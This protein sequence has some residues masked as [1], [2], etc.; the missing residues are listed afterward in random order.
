MQAAV[1]PPPPPPATPA[2][3][4]TTTTAR[5][6]AAAVARAVAAGGLRGRWATGRTCSGPSPAKS[7]CKYVALRPPP[8]PCMLYPLV[9]LPHLSLSLPNAVLAAVVAV[10]VGGGSGHGPHRRHPTRHCPAGTGHRSR[11]TRRGRRSGGDGNSGGRRR[12]RRDGGKGGGDPS[13]ATVVA[14]NPCT[15]VRVTVPLRGRDMVT[16]EYVVM[17]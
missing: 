7:R 1:P 10:G 13:R 17:W 8:L 14:E 9:S 4:T 16:S 6:A 15:R 2:M 12:G 5:T 3:A 11:P